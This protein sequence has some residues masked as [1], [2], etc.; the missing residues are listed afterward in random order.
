MVYDYIAIHMYVYHIYVYAFLNVG[1]ELIKINCKI[2]LEVIKNMYL[3]AL[4]SCLRTVL[5]RCQILW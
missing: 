3:I 5:S 1:N 2:S 4:M